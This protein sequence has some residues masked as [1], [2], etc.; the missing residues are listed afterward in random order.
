MSIDPQLIELRQNIDRCDRQILELLNSRAQYVQQVG[1]HKIASGN[2]VNFYCPDREVEQLKAL[3]QSNNGPLKDKYIANIFREIIS[4]CFALEHQI[5][6]AYLGPSGTFTHM[7][8]QSQFGN[9][10][11]FSP[12]ETIDDIFTRV[13]TD[14][15]DYG[16]VP[17]ENSSQGSVDHTLDN[18]VTSE[19]KICSEIEIAVD[20]ALLTKFSQ[21]I[22]SITKVYGHQQA[23]DQCKK[24]LANNMPHAQLIG[25]S[26][27]TAGVQLASEEKNTAAIAS[28]RAAS[29]YDMQVIA[30]HLADHANNTT[31]FV[32]IGKQTPAPASDNKTSLLIMMQNSSGS[33]Y[34]LLA[35]F[36]KYNID[37]CRL[38]T[39]PSLVDKWNY[40]F[41]IDLVGHS[42]QKHIQQALSSISTQAVLVK[43]LGSYPKAL[44]SKR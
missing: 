40:T 36:N 8:A 35:V 34:K 3:Q 30:Q 38:E 17:I 28:K 44:A 29:G 32:V 37:L 10:T 22:A 21:D 24:W 11:Q 20:H 18:F 6:V 19:L 39:R 2:A 7:A 4:G 14:N 13:A 9:S 5:N 33:L 25:V 12:I 23:L 31:R 41:Y 15:A 27:N 42:A 16:V 26:S 1:Q 43:N